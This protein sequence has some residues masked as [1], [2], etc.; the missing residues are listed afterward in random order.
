MS[1]RP[2]GPPSAT[3]IARLMRVALGQEPA[4]LAVTNA[5]LVNVYTGELQPGQG[6][7]VC[8][9]RIAYVG[10]DPS[11]CTGPDTQTIDAAGNYLSPG[12]IDC[13]AHLIYLATPDQMLRY[14]IP[15]GT[16][17]IVTES[18]E[19]AF[20]LGVRGVLGFLAALRGQPIK[21][22]A[23]AAAMVSPSP[24]A[25][26][27]A[28]GPREVARLLRQPDVLGLGETYWGEVLNGNPRILEIFA[29]VLK[30]GKVLEGHSAGARDHKLRA[31]LA[32]GVS[33]CHEAITASEALERARLG[34]WTLIRE[35]SVRRELEA[36]AAIKDKGIDT[37]LL[38]LTTDGLEPPDAVAHGYMDFLVQRAIEL[39]FPPVTAIQMATLN[40]AQHFHIEHLVGGIAPGRYADMMLLKDLKAIRPH[41][42]ISNGRVVAQEGKLLIPPRRHRFQSWFRLRFPFP[43]PDPQAFAIPAP[44]GRREATVRT[45][46]MATPLVT[47]EGRATLPARDGHLMVEGDLIKAAVVEWKHQPGKTFAAPL[48][49]F[50][51]KR[52]AAAS[53]AAWEATAIVAVGANDADLARA[54]G[55]VMEMGGGSAVVA[56]GQ[57]LAEV[58]LPIAGLMSPEPIEAVARSLD[59]FNRTLQNL[60]VPFPNPHLSLVTL[61]TGAIPHCRIT[62]SGLAN[63]RDGK[64]LDLLVE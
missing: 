19:I 21:L 4:D 37:R 41:L 58:P 60:G 43:P 7:A 8:G 10:P 6:V 14:V 34:I 15:G 51:L 63:L 29:T 5:T 38:C 35:G 57:V 36:V 26:A 27:E 33:S 31:Y 56:E 13:H 2:P 46:D 11:P 3:E 54:V 49:G 20:P 52:G 45:I 32:T 1:L 9:E 42:V 55:R 53:S 23:T 28:Y 30:A 17:T 48:R 18:L 12:F 61:T 64:I 16:T 40:P 59:H 22:L 47:R 39:G 62:E 50:G 24:A 44:A 25:Q